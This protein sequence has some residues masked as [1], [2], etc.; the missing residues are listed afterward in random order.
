MWEHAADASLAG[1]IY[2]RPANVYGAGRAMLD[3]NRLT[4]EVTALNTA[5]PRVALLYSQPSIFW[6]PKYQ[7]TIYSLYTVL[8]F[9]G[10]NVTFV[11]E[12][13]LA[14]GTAAKVQWLIVPNATH[15]LSWTPA[16]LVALAKK[17]GQI[18]L[19]GKESLGRDEYDRPLNRADYPAMELAGDEPATAAALRQALAPLPFNDLHDVATGKPAWGVEFRVVQPGRATLVALNNFNK[20]AKTVTL[21]RWAKEP[22]LD[23]LSGERVDLRAVSVEPMVP[24]LLRTGGKLPD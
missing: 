20:E 3:L 16:A 8:N 13:Q 9:M 11:S 1:S 18:L 14:E 2:F 5:W 19:V 10:E 21:P 23:L 6:E 24:R 7:G 4:S 12:R 22:A 17:G 15:V